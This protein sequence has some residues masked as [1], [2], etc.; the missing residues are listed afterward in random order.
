[1]SELY[2]ESVKKL[3]L[4]KE[5]K[6]YV[7]AIKLEMQENLKLTVLIRKKLDSINKKFFL[8][9]QV[10]GSINIS[11]QVIILIENISQNQITINKVK[12]YLAKLQ[13]TDK[14]ENNL[15]LQKRFSKVNK[16]FIEIIDANNQYIDSFQ[17][18]IKD[19][20]M[21]ENDVLT[22]DDE[23]I[24]FKE[25]IEEI[26]KFI[27][28]LSDDNDIIS[29]RNYFAFENEIYSNEEKLIQLESEVI[30]MYENME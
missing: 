9:I 10:P 1:L 22:W 24:V 13:D 4:E 12:K 2:I 23:I 27:T 8:D 7:E 26:K 19:T 14:Y 25:K 16:R 29:I 20:Y 5:Y 18:I 30:Y 28:K 21:Q 11:E 17:Q 6:L 3:N 15:K